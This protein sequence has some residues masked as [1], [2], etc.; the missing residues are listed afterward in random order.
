MLTFELVTL[1]GVKHSS[2]CY[3]VILPTGEGQ[4]AIFPHHVPLVSV[5]SPG[6]VSVRK[7]ATDSDEL[8]QHFAT[9]GGVIEIN[10]RRVRLLTD[11]AETASDI[12]HTETQAALARARELAAQADDRVATADAAALIERRLAQLKVTELSN[13]KRN[14]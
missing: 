12:D 3:E 9:D 8:L 5:A 13:R 10:D 1:D 6:V 4:I 2:E 14:R 11:E 7:R